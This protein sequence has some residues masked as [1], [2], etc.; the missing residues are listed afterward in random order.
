MTEKAK[1]RL[2]RTIKYVVIALPFVIGGIGF[3]RLYHGNVISAFYDSLCLYGLQLNIE[4]DVYKR[5]H[6]T[7]LQASLAEMLGTDPMKELLIR[8][9]KKKLVFIFDQFERFFFLEEEKKQQVRNL[10]ASL[11]RENTGMILSMREEYLAEFMKEFDINNMMQEGALGGKEHTG[12]LNHLT[13]VIR[14]DKKQYY[15][16][17]LYTSMQIEVEDEDSLTERFDRNQEVGLID[18]AVIRLPRISNF[19]DFNP[20]ESCLLYTSIQEVWMRLV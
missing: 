20:F 14:E 15:V 12:I 7:N 11:S 17:L 13:S 3:S 2:L 9:R 6:Y 19:T 16:C 10:I 8:G 5:Q 4:K 18:L 1:R